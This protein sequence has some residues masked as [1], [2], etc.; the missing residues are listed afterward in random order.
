MQRKLA[1]VVKE[2]AMKKA[3][4]SVGKSW[5][6]GVHEIKVPQELIR[7]EKKEED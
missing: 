2:V 6:Y 1:K 3:K 4:R 5:T 7:T